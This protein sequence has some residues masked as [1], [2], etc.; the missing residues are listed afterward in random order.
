MKRVVILCALIAG[1]VGLAF[2]QRWFRHVGVAGSPE[3]LIDDRCQHQSA[4]EQQGCY[5]AGL[6]AR[7]ADSGVAAAMATLKALAKGDSRFEKDGHVYAHGVGIKAY[8]LTKDVPTNFDHCST[9]FASGCAHGVIQGYLESQ[10]SLTEEAL[11]DLCRPYRGEHAADWQ[12]FQCVH[13]AGHGLVMMYQGDLPHALANCDWLHDGWDRESCYGGAFMENIMRTI[14][15]HHPASELSASHHQHQAA[16]FKALDSTDLLYPCSQVEDRFHRACYEIQTAAILH[17]TKGMLVPA[18]R[19]CDQAPDRMRSVCYQ[20]LG[21]DI[22]AKALRDPSRSAR[23]CRETGEANL[24]WCYYGVAKALVDWE[25]NPALGFDF[26]R[27]LAG[28]RGE[29][30]CFQAVGEQ[31]AA[32]RV[33]LVA[34]EGECRSAGHE[35]GVAACRWGAALPGAVRPGPDPDPGL[36]R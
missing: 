20:S 5:L 29:R 33:D 18:A 12:R 36:D 30:L 32:L 17:F 25:A 4:D 35:P 14:A 22:T 31:I 1:V 9:D 28:E 27:K 8:L 3:R 21:R 10:G 16:T 26:C 6:E 15:P 23:Y 2:T 7:L 19:A 34:R 13:G 11:N 24:P